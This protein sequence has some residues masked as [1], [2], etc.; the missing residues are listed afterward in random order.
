[1]SHLHRQFDALSPE[2][3]R[4][5]HNAKWNAVDDDVLPLWVADMD[6]PIAEPIRVALMAHA[7]GDNFGYPPEDGVPGVREACASRVSRRFGWN[8][9]VD[10]VMP[11]A[12]IIPA[13]FKCVETFTA[14][15]DEILLPTPLYPWFAKSVEQSG[16]VVIPVDLEQGGNER[17]QLDAGAMADRITPATRMV[18]ICNPHN[19]TGRVFSRRELE[20][21]A[22]M[23]LAH[24][25]WIVSDELHAD[26]AYE[27]EHIPMAS[28]GA[29]VAARTI[30]L[31][32]P[33]KAFNIAGLKVGFAVAQD[34][35]V[36]ER[37]SDA[38]RGRLPEPN[39]L[40]QA[41]AIAAF[42]A[43]DG[44]LD[45][46]IGYLRANRSLVAEFVP[47]RLPAVRH[48]PPEATYL[49]WLDFRDTP[50][51]DAP[52]QYLREHARVALNEGSDYGSAG[53]GFARLN[54]ATSR[55]IV[56]AALDRIASALDAA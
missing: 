16:R 8:V 51:A 15:G 52:A 12:G 3:L 41:A 55:S 50:I 9:A 19:P 1:M 42:D 33:T 47:R 39:V 40:A 36:M 24:D 22:E 27:P 45:E 28:L 17:Y 31:Y 56:S 18:M 34:P 13:M 54:F 10:H 30:T 37:L 2:M 43:S 29:D 53:R 4:A 11:L 14:A 25:L 26:L 5:R 38:C 6:L 20:A 48:V 23:A 32:G 35:A 49:A 7:R 21:V 46:T 44:W